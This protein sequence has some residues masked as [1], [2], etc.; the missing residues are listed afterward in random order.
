[1]HNLNQK[2]IRSEI[3][4]NGVGLHSGANVK[5]KIKPAKPNEGIIFIRTDVDSNIKIKACPENVGNTTL[6][7]TLISNN[8]KVSTVEHL[9]SA[10][11]GLGID[12][13]YVHLDGPDGYPE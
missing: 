8:I 4:F 7:T 1:M 10:I 3:N 6:S 2:T 13:L 9:L 11:A 12:N 5:L